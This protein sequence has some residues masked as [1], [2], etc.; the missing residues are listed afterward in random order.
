MKPTARRRRSPA[1]S[2]GTDMIHRLRSGPRGRVVPAARVASG[3][4]RPRARQALRRGH[5]ETDRNRSG[6]VVLLISGPEGGRNRG[7]KRRGSGASK[8]SSSAT[9]E[10]KPRLRKA[11]GL[12]GATPVLAG[13]AR[14]FARRTGFPPIPRRHCDAAMKCDTTHSFGVKAS[15]GYIAS[16]SAGEEG[17]P[18]NGRLSSAAPQALSR[19]NV[20][21]MD[22]LL[23][24]VQEE[25]ALALQE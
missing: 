18:S 2:A 11:K 13:C 19:G 7:Y 4:P 24:T 3:M 25:G 8:S 12:C 23:H 20:L 5:G 6:R 9:I 14:A 16:N 10:C 22:E 1:T 17:V 21:D 15:C